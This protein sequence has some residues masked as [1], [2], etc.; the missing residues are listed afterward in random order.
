MIGGLIDEL[1]YCVTA[2]PVLMPITP[3]A[4]VKTGFQSTTPEPQQTNLLTKPVPL[5]AQPNIAVAPVGGSPSPLG[6]LVP[7]SSA[8]LPY[9]GSPNMAAASAPAPFYVA[10]VTKPA[11]SQMPSW[12]LIP[13]VPVGLSPGLVAAPAIAEPP[14]II[15]PP[16]LKPPPD[17]RPPVVAIP[18]VPLRRVQIPGRQQGLY[19]QTVNN[20]PPGYAEYYGG[21]RRRTSYSYQNSPYYNSPRQW[22]TDRYY[23]ASSYQRSQEI[24]NS[25]QRRY[26]RQT[27]DYGQGKY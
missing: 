4:P 7:A 1:T 22:G 10:P 3:Q 2:L 11:S 12:G 8:S 9:I 21:N 26:G 16:G 6:Y 15:M 23:P 24:S 14:A 25:Y 18:R 5:P 20:Y 17:K 13:S 27:D 19:R